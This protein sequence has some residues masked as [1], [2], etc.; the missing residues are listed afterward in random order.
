MAER[1]STD[2]EKKNVKMVY[3]NSFKKLN[4][5]IG[6]YI[7][8]AKM[9]AADPSRMKAWATAGFPMELLWAQGVFNLMPENS[10]IIAAMSGLSLEM[11]ECSESIGY[12]RD[13]CSYMKTAMGSYRK[14]L[15]FEKFFQF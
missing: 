14:E 2:K 3:T 4:G 8:D 13:L 9:V 11:I 12:C 15:P 7:V 6:K 1:Q 5:V 10:A